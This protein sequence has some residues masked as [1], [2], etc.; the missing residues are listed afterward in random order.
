[1]EADEVSDWTDLI[2]YL[3]TNHEEV[4]S[5]SE[6]RARLVYDLDGARAPIGIYL[7]HSANGQQWISLNTRICPVDVFRNRSGLVANLDLPIGAF[8]LIPDSAVLQQTLPL[9]GLRV[10][11][12]EHTIRALAMQRAQLQHVATIED[13]DIDM[14]YAYV[15]R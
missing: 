10:A 8:C 14:P 9:G 4:R 5:A 11:N 3:E 12:L 13:A 1:M 15:F 6:T 2:T 7:R